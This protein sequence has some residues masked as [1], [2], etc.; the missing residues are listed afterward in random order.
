MHFQALLFDLDDTLLD[1]SR[2]LVPAAHREAAEAMVRAGLPTSLEQAY[3]ARLSLAVLHPRVDVNRLTARHFHC[4]LEPVIEAGRTA[5]YHR[6]IGPLRLEPSVAALLTFL[7]SRY[8]LFLVTVGSLETQSAKVRAL[9]L[10]PWFEAIEYVDHQGEERKED[11][12]RALLDRYRLEAGRC[13]VIGDRPDAEI[14]AGNRLGMYTVRLLRGEHRHSWSE[15][16]EEQAN[17]ELLQL[18]LLIPLLER[19]EASPTD[20]EGVPSSS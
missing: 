4:E 2:L 6:K 17:A 1:T 14:A 5:F 11:R 19:L 10:E 15:V 20:S 12:F 3:Q 16:T 13:M 9:G 7:R 18:E 8:R